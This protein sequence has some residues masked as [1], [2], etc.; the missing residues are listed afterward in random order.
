MDL[1]TI[2]FFWFGVA[3]KQT[4]EE[5]GHVSETTVLTDFRSLATKTNT[6][7]DC[8]GKELKKHQNR[9][10]FTFKF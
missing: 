4:V 7:D 10:D 6:L 3:I 1:S 5:I 9:E 2:T 8:V